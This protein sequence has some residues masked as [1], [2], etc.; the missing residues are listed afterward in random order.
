M[1]TIRRCRPV[2][3]FEY[4]NK[5]SE[6]HDSPREEYENFFREMSYELHLLRSHEAKQFDFCATPR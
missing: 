1:G 4:E 3:V 2:I 5:L 6:A